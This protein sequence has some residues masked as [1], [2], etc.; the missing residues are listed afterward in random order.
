[1]VRGGSAHSRVGPPYLQMWNPHI[2]RA[3]WGTWA[4]VDFGICRQSWK[5]TPKDD[6]CSFP[7]LYMHI[8]TV[9]SWLPECI[10]SP[11]DFGL[12][13]VACFCQW[14]INSC[15][16]STGFQLACIADFSLLLSCDCYERSLFGIASGPRRM[17]RHVERD[18]NPIKRLKP[19]F[20]SPS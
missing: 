6:C 15:D 14:G 13:H 1:M 3:H 18:P 9:A 8:V 7:S 4:A 12:S 11:L 16:I 5:P 19:W 2:R 20:W 10:Y 17:W